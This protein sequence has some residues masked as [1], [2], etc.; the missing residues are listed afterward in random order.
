MELRKYLKKSWKKYFSK[1]IANIKLQ[2]RKLA[3]R[4]INRIKISTLVF[5]IQTVENQR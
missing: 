5:H 3:Q 1:L 2:N 4:T